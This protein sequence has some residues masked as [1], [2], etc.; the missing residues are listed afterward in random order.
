MCEP[1]DQGGLGILD[2]NTK[3]IALLSKWL[4]KLPMGCG[5]GSK[6]LAQVEWKIEDSHF[7]SCLMRV[8]QDFLRFGAF[9][10]KYGFQED[11]WLSGT[12]LK[13]Q[14]HSLYNIARPKFSTIA[15]VLSASPPSISWRRQLFGPN[16]DCLERFIVTYQW[17]C[18][19]SRT[20]S[21]L[22]ELNLK[23]EFS[24]K[25]RYF[26]LMLR[27]TPKVNKDLLETKGPLKIKIFFPLA[28]QLGYPLV[29]GF[30]G[31]DCSGVADLGAEK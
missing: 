2:L 1:K 7:W 3:N 30:A 26:V 16:F 27:Y 25:S 29:G 31:F 11:N 22:L 19:V 21:L 6:P 15:D 10:V 8:K 17:S 28:L 9:L 12:L 23:W 14:Y 13:D 18:V 24:I 5:M 4:Y 20:R